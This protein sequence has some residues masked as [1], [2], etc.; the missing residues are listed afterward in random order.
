MPVSDEIKVLH[1]ERSDQM[2]SLDNLGLPQT[3]SRPQLYNQTDALDELQHPV[4]I[5]RST[6]ESASDRTRSFSD[7]LNAMRDTEEIEE[8]KRM[9][10]NRSSN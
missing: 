9:M 6:V 3:D 10:S 8:E 1:F 5:K 4:M 2:D 7:V